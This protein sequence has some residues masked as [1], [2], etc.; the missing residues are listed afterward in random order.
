MC[1]VAQLNA[2][3]YT[4]LCKRGTLSQRFAAS[5]LEH[6]DA[7]TAS[8]I[9]LDRWRHVISIRELS[10]EDLSD[11]CCK[12]ETPHYHYVG[13][14]DNGGKENGE[15]LTSFLYTLSSRDLRFAEHCYEWLSHYSKPGNPCLAIPP[16]RWFAATHSPR[17]E[18]IQSSSGEICPDYQCEQ[19]ALVCGIHSQL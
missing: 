1:R 5:E 13:K 14:D 10:D 12:I 11:C 4:L 16:H 8:E 18:G 3:R 9:S 19:H 6:T 15:T 2:N 7:A 17:S